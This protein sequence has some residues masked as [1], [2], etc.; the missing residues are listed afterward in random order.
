[1]ALPVSESGLAPAIIRDLRFG[2]GFGKDCAGGY[3]YILFYSRHPSLHTESTRA[4]R[5]DPLHTLRLTPAPATPDALSAPGRRDRSLPPG[6]T[7][8]LREHPRDPGAELP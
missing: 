8:F 6:R 7:R 2:F 3:G 1:M 5:D 4:D